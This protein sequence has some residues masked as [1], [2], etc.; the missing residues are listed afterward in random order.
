MTA[1]EDFMK[2]YEQYSFLRGV[3]E[4]H[5]KGE[6]VRG[7]V[8][9][10]LRDKVGEEKFNEDGLGLLISTSSRED[11]GN[12]V[13]KNVKKR[14]KE[15]LDYHKSNLEE[16]VR[17]ISLKDEN[18]TEVLFYFKPKTP[19]K[20]KTQYNPIV[21]LHEKAHSVYNTLK[22]LEEAREKKEEAAAYEVLKE[23]L[24]KYYESRYSADSD[25]KGF[26]VSLVE[27]VERDFLGRLVENKLQYRAKKLKE[28]IKKA[29]IDI[30]DYLS[31]VVPEGEEALDLYG[32]ILD[33]KKKEEAKKEYN[34]RI[35]IN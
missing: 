9:K 2:L 32:V 7:A 11:I 29:E 33:Y 23:K 14:K 20:N 17:T 34:K 8:A 26:L 6:D 30:R 5:K 24:K 15:T 10:L 35:S 4:A 25:I 19:R 13:E 16:I 31:A 12:F 3:E 18:L 28:E 27:K 21:K 22:S 1:Y